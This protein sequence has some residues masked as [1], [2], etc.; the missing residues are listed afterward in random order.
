MPSAFAEI[1]SLRVMLLSNQKV[2]FSDIDGTI[3]DRDTYSYANSLSAIKQLQDHKIPLVLCSAKT[4]AEMDVLVGVF[5]IK[6]PFIVENG[7]AIVIPKGYFQFSSGQ[8]EGTAMRIELGGKV[9]RFESK[10]RA[11]LEAEHI[12]YNSFSDMTPE[13]VAKHTGMSLEQSQLARSREYTMTLVVSKEEILRAKKLIESNGLICFSGGK[14]LT[15]GDTGN[16]GVAVRRLSDLYTKAHEHI[17]TYAFG[18][19]END[20]SMLQ[21][22]DFPILVQSSTGVWADSTSTRIIKI[23]K[24]GPD[25]FSAGVEDIVKP[26]T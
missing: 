4:K 24:V 22:V 19:G 16:K 11:T 2:V 8:D 15:V 17:T 10:L 25:G 26:A 13:S 3:L 12:D 23:P 21:E 9:D 5:G 18:D 6:D 1:E 14:S 7:S 20:M